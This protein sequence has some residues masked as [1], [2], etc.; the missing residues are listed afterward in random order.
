MPFHIAVKYKINL[1][2]WGECP[3]N[4]YGA[5]GRLGG[6]SN[7]LDRKWMEEFG[8]LSG[9]RISDAEEILKLPHNKILP[10]I[11]PSDEEIR[12]NDDEKRILIW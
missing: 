11:Y 7:I 6:E 5:V 8:G 9:F 2:I 3:Q 10:F 12:E 4:E 1:L